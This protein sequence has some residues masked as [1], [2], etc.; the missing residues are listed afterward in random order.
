MQEAAYLAGTA[1]DGCGTGMAHA[2]GHALGTL[3]HIPH[4]AAVAI[5]LQAALAWNVAGVPEAFAPVGV[6][7][8]APVADL[9]DQFARLCRSSRFPTV[10]A[11]L[12][13]HPLLAPAI[14]EAMVAEE[15][16]P[17]YRNNVRLAS[18]AERLELATRTVAVWHE[19]RAAAA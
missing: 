9:P 10:V 15:N 8:G 16:L 17:M 11:A 5:G 19:L 6:T 12:P 2:I 18:D 3:H 1:I 13:D 4:G 7:L 14:A